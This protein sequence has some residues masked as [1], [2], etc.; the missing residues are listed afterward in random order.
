[1]ERELTDLTRAE[2]VKIAR[3]IL[4]VMHEGELIAFVKGHESPG[5]IRELIAELEEEEDER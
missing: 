2:L 5:M 4:N 3:V 1:M